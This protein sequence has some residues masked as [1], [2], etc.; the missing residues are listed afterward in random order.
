MKVCVQEDERDLNLCPM[1]RERLQSESNSNCQQAGQNKFVMCIGWLMGWHMCNSNPCTAPCLAT[2]KGTWPRHRH[3]TNV[4]RWAIWG[5][6][7]AQRKREN[8]DN[9]GEPGQWPEGMA[10]GLSWQGVRKAPGYCC[11]ELKQCRKQI[12]MMASALI[13]QVL[14]QFVC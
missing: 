11:E 8:G 4:E 5:P 9:A 2:D 6:L 7:C 13:S 1:L 14:R 10:G 3:I 12:P